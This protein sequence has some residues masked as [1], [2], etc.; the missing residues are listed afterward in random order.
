M[1]TNCTVIW[2]T[3]GLGPERGGRLPWTAKPKGIT[4]RQGTTF[5][6]RSIIPDRK[7]GCAIMLFHLLP[8]TEKVDGLVNQ[9]IQRICSFRSLCDMLREHVPIRNEVLSL[10]DAD[11][12]LT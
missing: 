4:H 5:K 10:E 11:M 12:L 7:L 1:L 3:V 9:C 2:P 8:Q 6:V